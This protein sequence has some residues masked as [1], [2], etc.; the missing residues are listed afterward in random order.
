MAYDV[1][2][3]EVKHETKVA[4]LPSDVLGRALA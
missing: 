4:S 2:Y 3:F 1:R